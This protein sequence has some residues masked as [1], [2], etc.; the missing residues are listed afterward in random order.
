MQF[1]VKFWGYDRKQVEESFAAQ[2]HQ[3]EQLQY[4]KVNLEA[5]LRRATEDLNSLKA[6]L[7]QLENEKA[8]A[9]AALLRANG[10]LNPLRER[11]TQLEGREQAVSTA[12]IH[13]DQE[14]ARQLA[15]AGTQA[16]EILKRAN[17][18][19]AAIQNEATT[20]QEQIRMVR[21][22][23][24]RFLEQ[25]L[26]SLRSESPEEEPEAAAPAG[27]YYSTRA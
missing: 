15:A 13:A 4:T 14:A 8:A 26:A 7:T 3:L 11:L 5:E 16:N 18:E 21:R 12:L 10:D 22:E 17:Q 23:A 20:L 24:T 9:E 2:T 6:Q 27:G 19:A 1:T 25:L